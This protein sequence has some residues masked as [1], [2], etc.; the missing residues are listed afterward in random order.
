LFRKGES[1]ANPA[2]WK[3]GQI[4]ATVLTPF[5]LALAHATNTFGLGIV[6]D[7]ATATQISVGII[8]VVNVVLTV[9][10]TDKIGV[11]P[12]KD[13]SNNGDK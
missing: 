8:A 4:T 10:T 5:L 7:E 3:T 11:L 12:T 13:E 1:V 2:A 6:V 9:T